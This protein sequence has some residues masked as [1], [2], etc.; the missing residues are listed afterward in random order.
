MKGMQ[1]LV[2]AV[3]ASFL[4]AAVP[5]AAA[6]EVEEPTL[7]EK[8]Q[9]AKQDYLTAKSEY[10]NA[11]A[12]WIKARLAWKDERGPLKLKLALTAGK[13]FM[14]GSDKHIVRYLTAIRTK[15]E[16][17]KVLDDA[18]KTTIF[19]EL[20]SYITWLEEQ[21]AKIDAATTKEELQEV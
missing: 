20:D 1:L 10:L 5:F 16:A 7:K 11:R 19:A 12:A 18:E 14:L 6:Q 9:Q 3:V 21:Q 8:Y 13:K 17:S 4:L 15:V 2:T